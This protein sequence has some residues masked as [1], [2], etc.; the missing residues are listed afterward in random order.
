MLLRKFGAR[1]WL[2][3]IV[4]AWGSVMLGMGFVK[5]WGQLLALRAVL[6]VFVSLA[7]WTSRRVR[8]Y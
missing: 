8:R 2:T 1:V 5:Q 6:G 4:V 3:T 7:P